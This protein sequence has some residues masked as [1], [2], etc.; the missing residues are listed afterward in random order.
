MWSRW[1]RWKGGI[2][3]DEDE[4]DGKKVGCESRQSV[5]IEEMVGGPEQTLQR[6]TVLWIYLRECGEFGR[7]WH[8]KIFLW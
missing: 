8:R 3:E 1:V 2:A 5:G 4:R 7:H 6:R